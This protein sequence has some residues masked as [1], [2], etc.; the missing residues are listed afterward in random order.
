MYK[1]LNWRYSTSHGFN[2]KKE[3]SNKQL[4]IKIN[5]YKCIYIKHASVY[6]ITS[7]DDDASFNIKIINNND[8]I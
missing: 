3:I 4:C 1:T 8:I 7:F 2:K 5:I 6:Y